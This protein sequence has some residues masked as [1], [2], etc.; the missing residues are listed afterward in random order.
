MEFSFLNYTHLIFSSHKTAT[1]TL[2]NTINTMYNA[3]HIHN[4]NDF[5]IVL[6]IKETNLE[7]K[8]I[9]NLKK[10]IKTHNHKLKIIT[11]IR[12]PYDRHISSFFQRNHDDL[13]NQK[14]EQENNTIVNNNSIN[15]L[16]DLCLNSIITNNS[17]YYDES[18]FELNRLFNIDILKNIIKK[19]NYYIYKHKLFVLYILNFNRIISNNSLEYI[20][21]CLKLNLNKIICENITS[22]KPYYKKYLSVKELMLNNKLYNDYIKQKYSSHKIFYTFK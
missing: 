5:N 16:Y 9:S 18:I 8:F 6:N 22:S 17:V 14:G 1:Q 11:I 13:I 15:D 2:L 19:D 10:Y 21:K 12:N 7:K 20:N 4:V 3:I